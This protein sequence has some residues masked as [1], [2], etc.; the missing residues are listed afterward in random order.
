VASV[1]GF[2]EFANDFGL[3][4]A[5]NTCSM[6]MAVTLRSAGTACA[7]EKGSGAPV[8]DRFDPAGGINTPENPNTTETG[9]RR[10]YA[11]STCSSPTNGDSS[12]SSK[13]TRS[14]M[15]PL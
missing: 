15:P 1:S 2:D 8:E 6:S 11:A 13:G 3:L 5:P 4:W 9:H 7:A 12:S 10:D 14:R